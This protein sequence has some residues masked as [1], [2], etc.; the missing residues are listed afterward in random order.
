MITVVHLITGLETGGA[1]RMLA[2]LVA[3]ADAGCC[4][5]VVVSLADA[6]PAAAPIVEAGIEC[7]GLGMNRAAPDPRG[8]FRLVR[9]LRQARPDIVQTWLYHADLMGLIAARLA[10]APAL[11][12]NLRCS[13]AR[14][15]PLPA[16]LRRLL[17][18][19][20]A[21]P[22]AVLVNSQAG[23]RFH[24]GTGYRPRRWE[25]VPNGFDTAELAPD[26]AAR[27][28]LRAE[29]GLPDAAVAIGLP[30]RFHPM[31][32]HATFMAAAKMLAGI[33]PEVRFVLAGAGTEAANPA[34]ARLLAASGVA[35][36][37]LALGERRDMRAFYAALDIA[38]LCSAWGEGF[39]NVLGEAMACGVPCVATDIGDAA[40][41]LR[42]TGL[43]VAPRDPAALAAAWRSLIMDGAEPRR[44]R[45]LAAR[46]RIRRDY[47]LDAVVGRYLALYEELAARRAPDRAP[48]RPASRAA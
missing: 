8:L 25:Y 21:I 38:T 16:A 41:L 10:P 5:S 48:A 22:D 26:I 15:R 6:G 44:A 35:E 19:L 29:L 33:H 45:G 2:R 3:R 12:W 39:P 14:L 4:R 27:A 13:D 47:E 23:R 24:E 30:A 7:I 18:R 36:R 17:A 43:V 37:V 20:S 31:K 9:L 46:A 1:E 32:D 42:D 40:D 28:R 34:F 11:L